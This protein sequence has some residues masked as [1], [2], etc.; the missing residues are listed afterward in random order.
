MPI[1]K[2]QLS[3]KD[4]EKFDPTPLYVYTAKDALNRVTVLKEANKDAY[5]IAGRYS[6]YN[7]DH[8][9]YNPLTEEESKEVEKL[10]RIGRKDATISF[11]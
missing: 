5:L 4:I 8:R 7:N 3:K 2:K 11:L 6:G 10:V 9:L 1:E